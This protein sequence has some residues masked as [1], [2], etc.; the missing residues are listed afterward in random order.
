MKQ[1]RNWQQIQKARYSPLSE[2]EGDHKVVK[3]A[4]LPLSSAY[5]NKDPKNRLNGL[6]DLFVIA[7]SPLKVSRHW[8]ERI[9]VY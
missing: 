1:M 7:I 5:I 6:W 8:R 4:F 9:F 3:G 2:K